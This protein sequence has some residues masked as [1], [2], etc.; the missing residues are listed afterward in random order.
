MWVKRMKHGWI[1]AVV[2][3]VLVSSCAGFLYA[4]DARRMTLLSPRC[5]LVDAPYLDATKTP[6]ERAEDLLSRMT[7]AEKIGQM[8]LVE[9]N[10]VRSLDDISQYHLGALLSGF[11]AKPEPNTPEAWQ[12]MVGRFQGETKKTC[13]QIPLLY[14]VDAVHGH[15]G[16]MG[17]TVFPHAIGLAATRDEDLVKRVAQATAAELKATGIY[18]NY[19]PNLDVATD[20]RWGRVYET[21]GNDT[22]LVSRLGTAY[23][24]G[25]QGGSSTTIDVLAT[26]KHF[27]GNGETVWG[28][29]INNDYRLDQGTIILKEEDL[30]RR[31]IEPFKTAIENGAQV[32]MVGLNAWQDT[33]LTE[34]EYL[35]T[36]VL[37]EELGFSGFLVS[38]WYGVYAMPYEQEEA[39]K[40]AVNSGVDMVMLPFDYK[41]YT[42]MME[43][44]LDRGDISEE[45]LNDAVRRILRVKFSLGLF[46]RPAPTP[47]DLRVLRSDNHQKL[48]R[49][50]VQKSQTLLKNTHHT[51]P[52]PASTS[53]MFVAGSAADN[54]GKQSG[55]WT[56]EWQGIDGNWIPGTTILEGIKQVA[57]TSTRVEFRQDGRF[58]GEET[59]D[60]GIAVVGEKPYAEGV[61]DNAHPVLEKDDLEAIKQLRMRVKKLVVVI[62]SG[63]PLDVVPYAQ[64]WDVVVAS[65][66]PGSEGAGVADVLFGHVPFT[67]KMPVSWNAEQSNER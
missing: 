55:G 3:I 22:A 30:R 7:R 10:S 58:P 62:V 59:A 63:R 2:F 49:E 40:R 15:T 20:M 37:K 19:A 9:K 17:A 60:I 46:D 14:G 29:S 54:L 47:D 1:V 52:I 16:V 27:V 21:Y 50:A 18:W 33:R 5:T 53:R 36:K 64:D 41:T 67:G 61:G 35:L 34:H 57:S 31:H 43:R 28:T 66:L 32:I 26:P 38:D 25:L 51:L 4:Q 56:I 6:E 44:L 24:R 42:T 23:L 13:L 65:W 8:A 11:G 48:A 12:E 45:R 39:L